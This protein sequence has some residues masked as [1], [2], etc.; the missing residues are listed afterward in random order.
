MRTLGTDWTLVG[1]LFTAAFTGA[2]AVIAWLA[3]GH[4]RVVTGHRRPVR[5]REERRHHQFQS[6]Y[7]QVPDTSPWD[8][9]VAVVRLYNRSDH[10]QFVELL[11]REMRLLL[12]PRDVIITRRSIRSL[13]IDPHRSQLAV[14]TF[15]AEDWPAR[16]WRYEATLVGH[17][18]RRYWLR[19][20][21]ELHSGEP[22]S[23][24]MR[25]RL[26]SVPGIPPDV[27][28]GIR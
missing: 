25:V 2:T 20:R 18:R 1:V 16:R 4:A 6:D 28:G 17:S 8:V 23:R 11:P 3:Y 5:V 24:W 9:R 22:I 13:D 15:I 21:G 27:T 19:V 7:W 10:E 14:I 26:H 12:G